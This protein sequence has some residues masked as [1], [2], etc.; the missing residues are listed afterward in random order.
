[1]DVAHQER[2]GGE[3]PARAQWRRGTRADAAAQ[4]A[5]Q[6]RHAENGLGEPQPEGEEAGIGAEVRVVAVVA[7]PIEAE[8]AH[9]QD[10][11]R[12]RELAG[13]ALHRR[14]PAA[15]YSMIPI[16]VSV[17]AMS[18]LRCATYVS[19]SS[20]PSSLRTKS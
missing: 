19:I 12:H 15:R 6:Q 9:R 11:Q 10:E 17:S 8:A 20:G 2:G 5:D 7:R 18:R 13:A 3:L 16:A 4:H 1:R 14:R